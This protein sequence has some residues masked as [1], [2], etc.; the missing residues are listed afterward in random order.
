[1]HSIEGDKVG[2]RLAGMIRVRRLSLKVIFKVIDRI[3]GN[4]LFSP[5]AAALADQGLQ[6]CWHFPMPLRHEKYSPKAWKIDALPDWNHMYS[7]YLFMFLHA[8]TE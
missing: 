2:L 1:M 7:S 5:I 6:R 3:F 8:F 4:I